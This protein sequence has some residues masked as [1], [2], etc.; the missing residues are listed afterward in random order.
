[1][2]KKYLPKLKQDGRLRRQWLLA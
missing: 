2:D 1:M